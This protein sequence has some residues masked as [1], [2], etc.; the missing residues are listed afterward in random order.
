MTAIN[1]A[2][3]G[4]TIGFVVGNFWVA[5]PVALASHFI[6]DALPHFGTKVTGVKRIKTDG[7][8]NYLV[9]EAVA[10]FGLVVVLGLERPVHWLLAAVC[11]FVAASP[12]LFSANRWLKARRGQAWKPNLY[13]KFATKIQWFERP[14]GGVVEI[15]WFVA[16]GLVI[17]PMFVFDR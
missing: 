14:I 4:A 5:V 11:A 6:C 15:A 16:F 12:D 3:T 17:I 13:S 10:C 2:L 7:F 8:R 9:A 1:H